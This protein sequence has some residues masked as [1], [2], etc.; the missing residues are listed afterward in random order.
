[1]EVRS[2]R[3]SGLIANLRSKLQRKT[4]RRR[5]LRISFVACNAALLAIV[6][7]FVS[8]AHTSEASALL[9]HSVSSDTAVNPLDQVSSA[10]IAVTVSRLSGMAESTAIKN[11]S[12]SDDVQ[13]SSASIIDNVVNKPQ[14]A[15]TSLKSNKDIKNYVSQSGESVSSI[16]AKFNVTSDSIRWSN[17][18]TGEMINAGT[19]LVIPPAG[20][21]G[22]VYVVK[23]GDTVDSIASKYS[24][25]KNALIAAN[26]AELA[27]IQVGEQIIIPNGQQPVP[28]YTP[29]YSSGSGFAWGGSAIY[30]YNGY[31]YGYCTWW[32]A[33]RRAAVGKPVPANLGNASSWGYIARAAGL[34]TGNTPQLYAA[35]VTSTRGEGH[36]VFVEAVNDD[37]S[38]V[39][40][41]MNH[42]GWAV[43]DTMTIDAA[44]AAGYI[45]IY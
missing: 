3:K 5:M 12:E 22:I 28:K 17:G 36:V 23:S 38:I 26:D 16:A 25:D 19:K 8:H 40:S 20:L 10:D 31:D 42:L 35:A 13:V 1:M 6:L 27:G 21:S 33:Q 44:T 37:G 29:T 34:P 45:Y 24:A 43:K 14:V 30:G 2:H 15:A 32:V 4:I 39:I 18:L 7:L 41:E 11:Q 9:S